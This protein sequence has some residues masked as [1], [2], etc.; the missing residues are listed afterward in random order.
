MIPAVSAN[1]VSST[2]SKSNAAKTNLSAAAESSSVAS[3]QS[4]AAT[5]ASADTVNQ[6]AI[7]TMNSYVAS[8]PQ[9]VDPTWDQNFHFNAADGYGNDI[10]SILPHYNKQKQIEYWDIYYIAQPLARLQG[11][12]YEWK[13]MTTTD[14]KSFQDFDTSNR[15]SINNVSIP[16]KYYTDSNQKP[17]QIASNNQND[18]PWGAAASG[19]IIDNDGLLKTDE[20]GN[21]I[22]TNA[23]LAYFTNFSNGQRIYLAYSN[24]NEQFHP[25]N[26]TA[27]MD[28]QTIPGLKGES[29]FRDPYV[30]KLANGKYVAYV[31]GGL[32]ERM[33]VLT[34][35]DGVNWDYQPQYTIDLKGHTVSEMPVV[36]T[37]NGQPMMFFI[38][39]SKDYNGTESGSY[40]ITGS[41]NT[42]GIFVTTSDSKVTKLDGGFDN[43]A[44]NYTNLSSD[45]LISMAW[46]G[47]WTYSPNLNNYSNISHFGTY[48]LARTIRYNNGN[49]LVDPI[50]PDTKSVG[51][52]N[53]KANQSLPVGTNNKVVL[54]FNGDQAIKLTRQ[55]GSNNN[56]GFKINGKQVTV[57]RSWN[58]NT[59]MS[60]KTTVNVGSQIN[61]AVLYIDNSSIEM[62]L[63]EVHKMYTLMTL[64]YKQNSGYKMALT[65]DAK[66]D[67]SSIVVNHQTNSSGAKQ[68]AFNNAQSQAH[69][70]VKENRKTLLD[71]WKVQLSGQ[72]YRKY[73][74]SVNKRYQKLLNQIQTTK[75][76]QTLAAQELA[77]NQWLNKLT[78]EAN[79]KVQRVAINKTTRY[80]FKV[81]SSKYQ[82][83]N[84]TIKRAKIIKVVK[85]NGTSWYQV[86]LNND[87]VYVK[88]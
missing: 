38:A 68:A 39:G 34:S 70:R 84:Q 59:H 74:A 64:S 83:A 29:D 79:R 61:Q 55:D 72:D 22:D 12:Q 9:I 36:K 81:G 73:A 24:N 62:Y 82:I 69:Q 20:Y 1:S 48:T 88:G 4:L 80:Y 57:S 45:K 51:Q 33:Y 52:Y 77:F 41:Y 67:Y 46:L 53:L 85:Q 86:K 47:N 2:T 11:V 17:F 26:S 87:L 76:S 23:K 50:E 49:F 19:S 14:F 60:K 35:S 5:S 3:V 66:V 27:V 54:N 58:L 25:F 65:N 42:D 28:P 37:I 40:V 16:D 10:Q 63:P 71:Q 18:I 56:V 32:K 21:K 78:T 75:N 8:N 43:F 30:T 15:F 6:H 13:H 44:G 31:A 7:D